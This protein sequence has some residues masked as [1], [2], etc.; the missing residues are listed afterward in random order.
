M[1]TYLRANCVRLELPYPRTHQSDMG[2]RNRNDR[3]VLGFYTG[4]VVGSRRILYA[5]DIRL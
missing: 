5:L 3:V 1:S 4:M 2:V